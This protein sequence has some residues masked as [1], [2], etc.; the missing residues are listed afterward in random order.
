MSGQD[1]GTI[2]LEGRRFQIEKDPNGNYVLTGVH[3]ARY[4]TMRNVN[5]PHLMFLINLRGWTRTAPQGWLTD[6]NGK[7]EPVTLLN[8]R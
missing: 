2:T 6:R 5:T 3:G 7:L 1:C 4:R 8:A